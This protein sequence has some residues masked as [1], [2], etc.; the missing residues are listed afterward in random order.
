MKFHD[1]LEIMQQIAVLMKAAGAKSQRCRGE[2]EGE[3]AGNRELSSRMLPF[4][5]GSLE[6]LLYLQ[7]C[8]K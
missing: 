2:T 7:A 3:S 6:L 8:R 4:P 1:A 5:T